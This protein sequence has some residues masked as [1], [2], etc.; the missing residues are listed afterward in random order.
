MRARVGVCQGES[1][2][3][4]APLASGSALLPQGSCFVV[5]TGSEY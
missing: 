3:E 4:A 2:V 5:P 1:N